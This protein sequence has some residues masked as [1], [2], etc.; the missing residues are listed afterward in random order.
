MIS[1]SQ[2]ATMPCPGFKVF[3]A[4][5]VEL[6]DVPCPGAAVY[7]YNN[8]LHSINLYY[9]LLYDI[10]MVHVYSIY[11]YVETYLYMVCTLMFCE[12]IDSM[13]FCVQCIFTYRSSLCIHRV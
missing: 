6:E 11:I 8:I 3:D 1:A 7:G 5:Q 13:C 9:I 12:H 2:A 10:Y 4:L